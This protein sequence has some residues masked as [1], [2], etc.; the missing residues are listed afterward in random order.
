MSSP[1]YQQ[2]QY[3]HDQPPRQ[4]HSV[5]GIASTV[6]A[7]LLFFAYIAVFAVAGIMAE[8]QGGDLDEN[9]PQAMVVGLAVIGLFGLSFLG[10]VLGI[11]GIVLPNR[12][13]TFGWVGTALNA[14]ILV[15]VCGLMCLGL[16]MGHG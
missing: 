16:A 1:Y 7:V 2:D 10:L 4:P 13:K 6:L 3:W 8:R 15:G 9:S 14:F 12:N 5:L 11:V